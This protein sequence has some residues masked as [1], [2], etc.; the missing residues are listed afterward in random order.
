MKVPNLEKQ[1]G[2]ETFASAT[3]G[4]GG[5]IKQVPED[6]AVEELLVDGSRAELSPE[7]PSQVAGKGRYLVCMLVKRNWDTILAARKIAKQ[8]GISERRVQIAG[9]KD[10]KAVTAQ[11][12]SIENVKLKHLKR[13]RI[14]GINLFPLHYSPSMIFPHM[15][16]GNNFHIAIR[17]ISHSLRA[18]QERMSNTISELNKLGGIPNFFGHQRFGTIRPITHLV[19]KAIAQNNLEKAAL[20]FLA[21][22]SPFEHPQSRAARQKLTESR[23]F[24]EALSDFPRGLLYERLMLL[25]LANHPKDYV[26]AFRRLPKRLQGLFLQA[27]QSYLFNRF[28]SQRLRRR[29]P[30]NEPQ[31]GDYVVEVDSNRLPTNSY[32]IADPGNLE[33]LSKAV[34]KGSKYVALP[35]IG[36]KQ[37]HSEG[38][39]GEVEHTI[40]ESENVTQ[41]NFFIPS[42]REMSARGELRAA[43]APIMNLKAGKPAKDD[44]NPQKKQLNI[45]F[46]LN[47]GCYATV[48]LREFMKSRNVI[49][50][51][52]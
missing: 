18:I 49:K 31:I 41:A 24:R 50:A 48:V 6:F 3:Q 19:G 23:D 28:L 39:Q 12:I 37:G 52:F 1:I 20:L 22:P 36:F 25:N 14:N 46:T 34:Q 51:G 9:I 27:F 5:T 2:V 42:A 15:S 13:I 47:R 30:I 44:S 33:A 45:S 38:V 11:Y 7:P 40:L 16:L 8:L 43:I 4:I 29:I 10:K 35:L 26:G 21:K 17:C 32:A